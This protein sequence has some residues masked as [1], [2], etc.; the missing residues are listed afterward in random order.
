MD[1]IRK[2]IQRMGK[3]LRIL[4][5]VAKIIMIVSC[6]VAA[7]FMIGALFHESFIDYSKRLFYD[8]G[9]LDVV[10]SLNI[11]QD[12]NI[13][14]LILISGG[15]HILVRLITIF[16]L[17][18]F[19]KMFLYMAEGG[20]PFTTE[21]AKKIRY[22]SFAMILFVFYN[23]LIGISF[24]FLGLLFS[25]L[26]EYGAYLQNKADETNRIQEE[27]I[28]SFAEITETKSE[29]TGQHVRRVAE[30]SKL[31]AKE[32]G[33]SEEEVEKVRLASTMHDIG[34]L[35]IPAEI[36]EKPARLTDEEFAEIKK[37]SGYGGKL[38]KSVEGDVMILARTI[39][40]DHHERI[41]GN[42]YPD[43]KTG[44]KISR[45]GKIVAVADVYDALTSKRSYKDA[46]EED[47]AYEEIVK[48]SGTQFDSEVVEAFQ[49]IYP[50]INEVR[51]RFADEGSSL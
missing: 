44:E 25:Y 42:G 23:P 4:C 48:G 37:H 18:V 29:Q 35:L 30:Y 12:M 50:Q 16:Y 24:V 51:K 40:L 38:L 19:E 21:I 26:F 22:L 6:C 15:I 5:K 39:A 9:I 2:R 47:R 31:L 14:Y 8:E 41:D 3:I 20:Q 27:M 43:G 46:W 1:K 17:N 13:R 33:F 11:F 34:K 36:L 28:I 49:R 7:V 32:M 10:S 45:E